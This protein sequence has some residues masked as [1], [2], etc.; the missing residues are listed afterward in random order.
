MKD[1]FFDKKFFQY[2]MANIAAIGLFKINKNK[3][4]IGLNSA[5]YKKLTAHFSKTDKVVS[6]Y[7]FAHLNSDEKAVWYRLITKLKKHQVDQ[8]CMLQHGL[9]KIFGPEMPIEITRNILNTENDDDDSIKISMLINSGIITKNS[10]NEQIENVIAR[11]YNKIAEQTFPAIEEAVKAA[12]DFVQAIEEN[13][14]KPLRDLLE[15][16]KNW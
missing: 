3:K 14:N 2:L 11:I 7:I 15:K 1:N 6:A 12:D 10:V 9:Y 13:I 8:L 16:I 4:I 5:V